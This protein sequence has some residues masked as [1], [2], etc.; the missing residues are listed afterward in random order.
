M[1]AL[2]RCLP[3]VLRRYC[4]K[5]C[6]QDAIDRGWLLERPGGPVSL[7][8]VI[9]T[10]TE[11]AAGMSMLHKADVI[12]GDLSP[13]NVLLSGCV[14]VG[15]QGGGMATECQAEESAA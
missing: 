15:L 13:Y 2:P 12:H 1:C 6:L 3:A 5:G 10:A 9:V 7:A 11:V 4:N 14:P 8:K